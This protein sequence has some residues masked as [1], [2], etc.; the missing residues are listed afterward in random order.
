MRKAILVGCNIKETPSGFKEKINECIMLCEACDIEVVNTVI[1]NMSSINKKTCIG[2]GKVE[3]VKELLDGIDCVVFYNDLTVPMISNLLDELDTE[4]IDRTTLILDIFAKRAKSKEAQIQVE[5]ARLKYDLP[6]LIFAEAND[7]Q[8]RGGTGLNNRGSGETRL[9]LARRDIDYK[10]SQLRKELKSIETQKEVQRK[11]RD[12]SSLKKVALVGYTN[13]GKS[14]LMNLILNETGRSDDKQVLSKDMLFATLDTSVRKVELDDKKEFLLI[15]TV[16]FVSD[17]PHQL[18]EAFESTLSSVKEA[19]LLIHVID[20][21]SIYKDMHKQ[22]TLE[23]LER[24]GASD[25]ETITV[26]N[27]S[28]LVDDKD[29]YYKWISCKSGYGIDEL[30]KEIK[31]KCFSEKEKVV[32]LI[33]YSDLKIIQDL[34]KVATVNVI[35]DK[36]D[37]RLI[38]VLCSEEIKNKLNRYKV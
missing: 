20:G 36:E 34:V 13:T 29:E 32:C 14:S 17:L 30:F 18:I 15:D 25:I 37:G 12:N 26:Y 16:G 27:K 8:Q 11:S 7:D 28:D 5:M 38:E 9:E 19:D 22:V 31:S 1:Q 35:E 21:S 33:P 10:I 4:V 24:I 6:K 3:E 23:T 2:P